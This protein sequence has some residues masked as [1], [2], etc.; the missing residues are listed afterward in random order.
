MFCSLPTTS[1]PA[2]CAVWGLAAVRKPP[3]SACRRG[4]TTG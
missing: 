3:S 4:A 1:S 2:A